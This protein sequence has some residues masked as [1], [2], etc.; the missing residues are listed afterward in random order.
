MGSS[1][2]TPGHRTAALTRTGFA[3]CAPNG[4]KANPKQR[5]A[6]GG[7]A[8]EGARALEGPGVGAQEA[9]R[10]R[11]KCR[12]SAGLSAAAVLARWPCSP[13]LAPAALAAEPATAPAVPSEPPSAASSHTESF[14]EEGPPVSCYLLAHRTWNLAGAPEK[15]CQR[16]SPAT[17]AHYKVE[18][19][20][21]LTVYLKYLLAVFNFFFWMGGATVMAVGVWT[22]VEKSGYL[23]VLASSTFAASAYI[24]IFAG[25]LV[26]VTGFLG[27]GAVIREDR[28]CL[29]A[30][31][32]LL[33]AIFLV[34]LVA[35]VLAHVY[36]QRLSE[37]LKQHL[38][39]TLAENYRQPGAAEITASVDR[40][41]QDFRCCGS[42]SS[43]DWQHSTY[44]LSPEAEGRRVPDS[45]CKTVV[46]RCGQRAH[47]SNIY[48]VEGGCIT[49]LEQFLADHLLLMG[50]VGIGVAC[51]QICGMILTCCLH[52][53]VQLHFY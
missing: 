28:S 47:P 51:L 37:E 31:F 34:E 17:M 41:Q 27:F 44:I 3:S 24:L 29:S 38:T 20:D 4:R 8:G 25:T 19:D 15:L 46:A 21:W 12:A 49:K 50:A 13:A 43:A 42:N 7:A 5:R 18:Q 26:M 9:G 52:R 35:G 16:V 30:Y 23:G 22:L 33:L 11:R 14:A 1:L 10:G 45:C 2:W 48:K 32:C 53:R 36:Y 40:L 39:R 6:A